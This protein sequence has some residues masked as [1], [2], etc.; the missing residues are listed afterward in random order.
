MAKMKRTAATSSASVP[1]TGSRASHLSA[2]LAAA[3][4]L[5]AA[6][7]LASCTVNGPESGSGQV[8]AQIRAGVGTKAS[9]S[10]WTQDEIGVT[11]KSSPSSSMA[12]KYANVPYKTDAD[13]VGTATFTAEQGEIWFED[14]SETVTFTAYA[15]YETSS[16][17]ATLPGTD[18]DGI[19]SRSTADYQDDQTKI[20][21]MFASEQ[22]ASESSPTVNFVFAHKMSQIVFN[23]GAGVAVEADGDNG[24]ASGSYTLT[25]LVHEGT[26]NVTTGETTTE[27]DVDGSGLELAQVCPSTTLTDSG[28]GDVTGVSYTVIAYPQNPSELTFSATVGGK[29]YSGTLPIPTSSEGGSGTDGFAAGYSYTYNLTVTETELIVEDCIIGDWIDADTEWGSYGPIGQFV[30]PDTEFT[31]IFNSAP[32]FGTSGYVRIYKTDDPDNPVDEINVADLQYE[33]EQISSSSTYNTAWDILYACPAGKSGRYRIVHYKSLEIDGSTLTIRPHSC[34]LD[35]A[36]DYYITIDASVVEAM[37]FNGIAAGEWKFR[38][39]DAPQSATDLTVGKTG[40]DVDCR[41]IQYALHYACQNDSSTDGD[42]AVTV[43]VEDG[44]YEEQLYLFGKKNLT[45]KG[46]SGDRDKVTVQ[47]S[48]DYYHTYGDGGSMAS[49]PEVGSTVTS[50][51]HSVTMFEDC[52]GLRLQSMTLKNTYSGSRVQSAVFTFISNSSSSGTTA[53][54]YGTSALVDC[55]IVGRQAVV[56]TEGFNWFSGCLIAGVVDYIWGYSKICLFEDCEIRSCKDLTTGSY[57]DIV[58]ARAQNETDLG[59]VF[60]GCTLSTD[61]DAENDAY[62]VYLGRSTG[63]ESYY[64]N[65][66][67]IGC[68]ITTQKMMGWHVKGTTEAPNPNPLEATATSGWKYYG[69]TDYDAT[70]VTNDVYSDKW[71]WMGYELQDEEVSDYESRS[72]IFATDANCPEGWYDDPD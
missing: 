14:P 51:G 27:E 47:Y 32:S 11:V 66:A 58:M 57:K 3:V 29:P 62:D 39:V 20:D 68:T 16:D 41:T 33:D 65:A 31:V 40:Y 25:G 9:G 1:S 53:S 60:L 18:A 35:Y 46:E 26:F 36:T 52:D 17:V 50:G 21:F 34:V 13:G 72:T 10:L 42:A 70:L 5:C 56:M 59:Y 69:L 48:N 4:C 6:V 37:S 49:K 23:I 63:S 15:P 55:A 61:T 54:F 43:T 19:I 71:E 8:P 38:T 30:Y 45:I 24:V 64:D 44:T 7:C 28:S 67:F 2:P 22:T 12:S